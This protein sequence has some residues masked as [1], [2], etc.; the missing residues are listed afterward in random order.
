VYI[1][2]AIVYGEHMESAV[3]GCQAV[4]RAIAILELFD[5][6]RTLLAIGDVARELGV[7][8]STASRLMATLEAGGLLELDENGGGY[9]LGLGLVSLAGHVL[10]RFPVRARGGQVLRELRDATGETAWLGV[11]DGHWITYLDQASSPHVTVNVDWV[12]VRHAL[13]EGVTGRLLL[14]YQP[15]EVI[16]R[17]VAEAEPG[18]P[19]LSET[20]LAAVRRQGHALR[21]GD[22]ED[23][24]TGV[25]AP[26][27]DANDA[28][29]AA[30]SLGGPR[31]RVSEERLRGELLPAA[32]Q[33][34]ARV[35]E[36]LGHRAA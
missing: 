21:L 27:R 10:N 2:H 33:A 7:H 15:R 32:L 25:A 8:R 9:R 28:V 5:E 18:R 34:A 13:T 4:E 20:E 1:L 6:R 22:G 14:A 17:L 11:L 29:I 31:F 30:I 35:S 36:A 24:Y 19:G 3:S 16:D 23:G 26:I 12:G